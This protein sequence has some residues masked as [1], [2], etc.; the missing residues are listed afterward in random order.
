MVMDKKDYL[1]KANNLLEQPPYWELT[2]D[3]TGKYKAELLNILKRIKK[4][5]GTDGNTYRGKLSRCSMIFLKSTKRTPPQPIASSRYSV[6]CGVARE[7][8]RILQSLVGKYPHHI[9]NTQN[10]T[11]SIKDIALQPGEYIMYYN[12]TALFT[13]VPSETSSRHQQ[14]TTGPHPFTKDTAHQIAHHRTSGVLPLLAP[15]S[16]SKVS[17]TNRC[18]V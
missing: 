1:E 11:E 18:R 16:C 10:F 7:L 15:T 12:I 13:S 6:I 9:Q 4:E 3:P 5:S 2:S 8:A 17:I 14:V